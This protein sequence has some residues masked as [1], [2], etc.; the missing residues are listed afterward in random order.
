MEWTPSWVKATAVPLLLWT[1]DDTAAAMLEI[2]EKNAVRLYEAN[3]KTY[4]AI[5]KWEQRRNAKFPKFPAPAWGF[6]GGATH[7]LGGYVAPRARTPEEPGATVAPDKRKAPDKING[8]G[9]RRA[10]HAWWASED[11]IRLK[12]EELNITP[13]AGE[14]WPELKGRI[15]AE[16]ENRKAVVR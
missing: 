14:S 9:R 12:A 11:G 1:I 15:N 10:P 5:E 6:E 13:R 4:A 8:H 3:G 2:S 7:I 16:L